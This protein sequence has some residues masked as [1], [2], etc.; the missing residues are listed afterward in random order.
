VI[1]LLDRAK[2]ERK[3]MSGHDL[4]SCLENADIISNFSDQPGIKYYGK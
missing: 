2:N 1:N 4:L 3:K